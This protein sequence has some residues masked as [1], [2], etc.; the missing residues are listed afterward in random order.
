MTRTWPGER[1]SALVGVSGRTETLVARN[2]HSG[3][4]AQAAAEAGLNHAVQ[5][6]D[7]PL[8]HRRAR[9]SDTVSFLRFPHPNFHIWR[10]A[11]VT[12]GAQ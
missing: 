11:W 6:P 3:A 10:T 12:K 5:V 4:R 2:H 8:F 1:G 7:R 9:H